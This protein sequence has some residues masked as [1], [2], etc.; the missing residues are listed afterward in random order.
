MKLSQ[1]LPPIPPVQC[2]PSW[3]TAQAQFYQVT[4]M[5]LKYHSFDAPWSLGRKLVF[6]TFLCVL[7]RVHNAR[8]AFY[9]WV[10]I[11]YPVRNALVRVLCVSA[12]FVLF[13]TFPAMQYQICFFYTF[14]HLRN[15]KNAFCAPSVYHKDSNT[16]R[17]FN[18]VKPCS[19][20]LVLGWVTKLRIPRS[21]A[22]TFFSFFPLPFPRRFI[23]DCRTAILV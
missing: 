3:V 8:S 23:K 15:L 2:W 20:A 6:C 22:I 7:Y 10:H 4:F 9:T 19:P 17:L 11:L 14:S 16:F 18:K 21:V 13:S 5:A 1:S 12:C